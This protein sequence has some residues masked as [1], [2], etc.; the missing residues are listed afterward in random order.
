MQLRSQMYLFAVLAFAL[1]AHADGPIV[2]EY[3]APDATEDLRMGATTQD[4]QMPAAI[5]T[6]SG[7]LAAPAEQ[8]SAPSQVA[9]GG[10]ATPDSID[11]SYR[12]DRDTSRPESVR[13]DDPF[14]PAVTPFKRLYAYDAL[15]EGFE[16]VV[17]DK[18]LRPIEVGGDA[19]PDEDQF[20]GDL[21]V[22]IV[23]GVPVR[24]PSV[25]PGARVLVARSEPALKF[26]LVRDGAD[27]WFIVGD[28]RQRLRLV[29]ELS[30][31]RRVF[32]S[33]FGDA[34]WAELARSVPPLPPAAR[35]AATDV[36]SSMGISQSQRPRDAVRALVNYFRTFAPSDD[37]PHAVSGAALYS[38][39]AQSRKGVCRHRAYVFV[40][41]A[42]ALG[43]PA[44]LVRN[45][46]HAWVEVSDGL[47][48]HRVDLGGA[49]SHIDYEQHSSEHQ[50]QPPADPYQW[51]PGSESAQDL[52]AQASNAGLK[53]GASGAPASS[54][55]PAHA[56]R[57]PAAAGSG[58]NEPP[59]QRDDP[60]VSADVSVAA[61][62]HE[63]H[64]GARLHVSGTARTDQ[65]LCAFSRVDIALR[66]K[67]GA[68]HWLGALA[69]D[70][71]GKYDGRVALP[72]ELE[73]GDYSVVASTPGSAQ[74]RG[75]AR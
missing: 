46:A 31:P 13:Y 61:E 65:E 40:V 44:R 37:A 26:E 36:L 32:G 21:F 1:P 7:V 62:E 56:S 64:R 12:I 48:W 66:D 24:I 5:D 74:C 30:I 25:G 45:E 20:Y 73:V 27:N 10:S 15:D 72:L 41:S 70:Q 75:S 51:P 3:I 23:P 63:L 18:L 28:A 60:H 4:G 52:S 54:A 8:R 11:A 35:A 43:I 34:S 9:Y 53:P 39:L 22:D 16:L 71:S 69:T 55:A 33:E 59:A 42:L 17:H 2:H 58:A 6:R 67:T 38:E 68:E 57:P 29:L 19:R 47:S 49:A 14:I 50:H